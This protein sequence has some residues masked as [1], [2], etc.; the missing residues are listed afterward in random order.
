[1]FGYTREELCLIWLDSFTELEY[2][3]KKM[4]L[5]LANGVV[6]ATTIVNAGKEY[7]INNVSATVYKVPVQFPAIGPEEFLFQMPLSLRKIC[8]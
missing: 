5:D 8:G 3:H 4:L 6:D 7:L 1:M 2:K